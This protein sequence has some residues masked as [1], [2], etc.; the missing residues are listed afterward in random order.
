[1]SRMRKFNFNTMSRF[2]KYPREFQYDICPKAENCE[3]S[4]N[5]DKFYSFCL[6]NH[7]NCYMKN[8]KTNKKTS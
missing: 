1:M 2:I 4:K 8:E 3:D 5:P 7:K 6:G